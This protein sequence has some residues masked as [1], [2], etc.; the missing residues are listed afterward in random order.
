MG[1]VY[2]GDQE[3]GQAVSV[4]SHNTVEAVSP[5]GAVGDLLGI[6]NAEMYH[7]ILIHHAKLPESPI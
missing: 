2:G 6:M 7:L 3:R 4:Y 1:K 5:S